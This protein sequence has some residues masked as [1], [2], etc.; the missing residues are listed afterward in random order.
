LANLCRRVRGRHLAKTIIKVVLEAVS[1]ANAEE[2]QIFL[3]ANPYES[4]IL[5]WLI[6][7][8]IDACFLSRDEA[9]RVDG[10]CYFGSQYILS[11]QSDN[12][13]AKFAKLA[14]SMPKERM[15]VGSRTHVQGWW[16]HLRTWHAPPRIIRARQPLYMIARTTLRTSRYDAP[17]SP[18][19]LHE[20][21]EI[22]RE[23]AT[24]IEHEIGIAVN[25]N[26]PRFR[27]RTAR[28]IRA[29]WYQRLRVGEE[30]RF[31]CHIAAQTPQ[32]TQIQGVWTPIRL[33]KRGYATHALGALCD[34]LLNESPSLSL[35]VNDFNTEAIRLYERLGFTQVGEFMTLLF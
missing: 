32:S 25:P 16:N 7:S 15:I 4:V 5:Q 17:V 28:I 6:A 27:E 23:S 13:F 35:Y 9:G 34:Q 29:G 19:T 26:N 8:K 2:A 21:D 11:T 30:L 10:V 1:H 14:H 24:M 3:G 12:A 22:A 31:Q 20:L 33:R 18:A